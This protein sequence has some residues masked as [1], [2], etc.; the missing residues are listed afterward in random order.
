MAD[1]ILKLYITGSTPN[2][3]RALANLHRLCQEELDE[4]YEVK[5]IDV[6]QYPQLAEDDRILATPTLVKALPPPLR[7]VIGD[8]SDN[9][10][11]LLGLDLRPTNRKTENGETANGDNK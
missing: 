5:V 7:R 4:R 2:S 8:L 11:V 1:Y 10:K 9:E 6:L 3:E